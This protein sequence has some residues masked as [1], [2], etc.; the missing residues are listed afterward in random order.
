MKKFPHH[1]H[2]LLRISLKMAPILKTN[3]LD[4]LKGTFVAVPS[5]ILTSGVV[6]T[7]TETKKRRVNCPIL[8]YDTS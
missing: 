6:V 7:F 8:I 2:H 5:A 4:L 1:E 3:R